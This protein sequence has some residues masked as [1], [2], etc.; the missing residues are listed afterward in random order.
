MNLHS[1]RL[2]FISVALFLVLVTLQRLAEMGGIALPWWVILIAVGSVY[3]GY[4]WYKTSKEERQEEQK[5]IEQEGRIF[6]RRME[7]EKAKRNR[8]NSLS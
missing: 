6:I 2:L 1:K 7:D 8:E 3:C 5:W 4:M